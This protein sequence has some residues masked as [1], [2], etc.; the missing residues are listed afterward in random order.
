MNSE[1]IREISEKGLDMVRESPS[2]AH[3]TGLLAIGIMLLGELTAQ[4]S[5]LNEKFSEGYGPN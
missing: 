5:E 3:L 2:E 1:Q 4:V